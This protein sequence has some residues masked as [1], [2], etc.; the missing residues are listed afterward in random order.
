MKKFLVVSLMLV[1]LGG[2]VAAQEIG[3]SAEVTGKFNL[4]DYVGER[5]SDTDADALKG[6]RGALA[7][8]VPVDGTLTFKGSDDA[9]G[10]DVVFDFGYFLDS[11]ETLWG[12][13]NQASVWFK[14]LKSDLL[15]IRAGAKP[16]DATL[17]YGNLNST[18][19]EFFTDD[20]ARVRVEDYINAIGATE[21]EPY[22]LIFTTAPIQGLFIGLG[23]NAGP[24][25]K[26]SETAPY[27]SDQGPR[28]GDAYLGITVG[29]GYEISGIGAVR[30]QYYGPNPLSFTVDGEKINE[31]G[32][33]SL[34]DILLNDLWHY[35]ENTGE[36]DGANV[37]NSPSFNSIQAGFKLTALE[38]I[39]LGLDV[40]AKIPL[41]VK[42][43]VKNA[44]AFNQ[45]VTY[46]APVTI[47]VVAAFATGNISVNGGVGLA[48]PYTVKK[49]D[50]ADVKAEGIGIKFSA[51]P[52]I[53]IGDSLA[54]GADVA[55]AFNEKQYKWTYNGNEPTDGPKAEM[56]LGIGA[57]VK[58]TVGKG[59]LKA[60]LAATILSMNEPSKTQPRAL[61]F[62]IPL[63]LTVGF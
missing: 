44:G 3:V 51:E 46:G 9:A 31:Y 34:W 50:N 57:F 43:D 4:V 5:K 56:D 38:G 58:Y 1:L 33:N 15:T 42:V 8:T 32:Y 37:P 23:W 55:L 61:D 2:I 35:D 6:Y 63:T 20:L 24:I 41:G 62:K 22:A 19:E 13:N 29:A 59:T 39:G 25:G 27:I 36:I 16:S 12:D 52:A 28:I 40:V 60:G 26:T 49:Q 30:A 10:L 18:P 21:A 53:K 11:G 14:P 17:R 7:G 54:V 45:E 48:L 47:G